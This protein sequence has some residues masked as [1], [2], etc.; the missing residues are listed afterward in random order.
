MI[1]AE[2]FSS[3]L[4]CTEIWKKM[5]AY[6]SGAMPLFPHLPINPFL[7]VYKLTSYLHCAFSPLGSP[8][9]CN[10]IGA[11]KKTPGSNTLRTTALKNDTMLTCMVQEGVQFFLRLIYLVFSF[12]LTWFKKGKWGWWAGSRVSCGYYILRTREG[13]EEKILQSKSWLQL[14]S[15]FCPVTYSISVTPGW[16]MGGVFLFSFFVL[17]VIS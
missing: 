17:C 11:L 3:D 12:K 13:K 16:N 9:L 2:K 1:F 4:E 15:T 6:I 7:S 10:S 14:H 8:S 5:C